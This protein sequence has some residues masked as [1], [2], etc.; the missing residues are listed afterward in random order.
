MC[1]TLQKKKKDNRIFFKI[2]KIKEKEKKFWITPLDF[3]LF[4]VLNN[5]V[6]KNVSINS[7]NYSNIYNI[8]IKKYLYIHLLM[9]KN[10][11]KSNITLIDMCISKNNY[12]NYYFSDIINNIRFNIFY[13][14]NKYSNLVSI[15]N[16][17]S[18][19]TWVEREL[20]EFNNIKF[21]GLKDSRRLL[22]DYT[23]IYNNY[24]D[25]NYNIIYQDLYKR[26]LHWLFTFSFISIFI[27][28]SLIIYNK[29][30]LQLILISEVL[31]IFLVLILVLI[32]SLYNLY[33]LIGFSIL[34][35]ILGG[36]ELSLNLLLITIKCYICLKNFTVNVIMLKN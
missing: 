36:L 24:K 26:V 8:K 13:N 15:S 22:T 23:C 5:I 34:I 28:S 12:I 33:Y 19:A 9:L 25:N 27:L 32:S 11:V 20:I 6:Y 29:S 31:I 10:I 1:L 2:V 35:I 21:I 7:F 30:L 16:L 18:S 17:Y 4:F 14:I 3:S